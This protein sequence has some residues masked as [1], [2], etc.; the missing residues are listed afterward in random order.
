MLFNTGFGQSI[1]ENIF[2][3]SLENGTTTLV[4]TFKILGKVFLYT[5][6]QNMVN[7]LF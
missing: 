5:D 6:E 7:N 1:I 2:A 3:L 4:H